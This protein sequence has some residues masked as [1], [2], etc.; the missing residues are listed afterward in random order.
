MAAVT[1]DQLVDLAGTD[2]GVELGKRNVFKDP[3]DPGLAYEIE[4][5]EQTPSVSKNGYQQIVLKLDM[6]EGGGSAKRWICLPI[7]SEEMRASADPEKLKQLKGMWGAN[8]HNL[9][10]AVDPDTY[11]IA[12][13]EK[14]AGKWRFFNSNGD[15]ITKA[16]KDAREKLI[17][18]AVIGAATLLYNGELNLIGLKLWYVR[19]QDKSNPNKFYDN[20]Y[21]TQPDKFPPA[22]PF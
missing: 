10:R 4:I 16:E 8:L 12:R 13:M 1:L 3:F 22:I 7:F 14:V 2:E 17:G 19:T 5:T 20:F 6:V 9:L 21:S 11:T 18:K 15:E